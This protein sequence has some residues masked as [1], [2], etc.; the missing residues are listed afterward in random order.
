MITTE[1]KPFENEEVKKDFYL[2]IERILNDGGKRW[3]TNEQEIQIFEEKKAIILDLALKGLLTF[4]ENDVILSP[5]YANS[6]N[7]IHL[8]D[9]I[10][11]LSRYTKGYYVYDV[12]IN[13]LIPANTNQA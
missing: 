8:I 10:L 2:K 11:R 13:K 12:A 9:L 6:L 3:L 1:T 4:K 7:D 5:N